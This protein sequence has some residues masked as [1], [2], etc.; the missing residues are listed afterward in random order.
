MSN[1]SDP[2][3]YG[4]DA[5]AWGASAGT[6]ASTLPKNYTEWLAEGRVENGAEMPQRGKLQP[7]V[8]WV[9][10]DCLER[11]HAV[12]GNRGCIFED[13]PIGNVPDLFDFPK[14]TGLDWGEDAHR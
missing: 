10:K 9:C 5:D 2:L 12:C 6:P 7:K 14:P 3:L 1:P 11:S 8:V 13:W 4:A